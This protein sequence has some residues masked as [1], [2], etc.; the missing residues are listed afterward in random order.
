MYIISFNSWN[1][2]FQVKL[3]LISAQRGIGNIYRD[4]NQ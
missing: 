2:I 3:L 1:D 4:N